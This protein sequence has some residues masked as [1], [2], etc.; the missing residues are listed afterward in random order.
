MMRVSWN[1]RNDS[2]TKS[3]ERE[4]KF[5]FW[6]QKWQFNIPKICD[7]MLCCC[8][9]ILKNESELGW[10]NGIGSFPFSSSRTYHHKICTYVG[11]IFITS[12]LSAFWIF[13]TLRNNLPLFFRLTFLK[14][15]T[16]TN[17]WTKL[18][19]VLEKGK[20]ILTRRNSGQIFRFSSSTVVN[21]KSM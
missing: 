8:R 12:F 9:L 11:L 2:F 13:Q 20:C 1:W 17:V 6:V 21:T 5:V 10:D 4:R 16:K 18:E 15:M 14:F 7:K 19:N 3:N